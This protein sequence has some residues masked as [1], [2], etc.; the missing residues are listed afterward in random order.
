[1]DAF[2]ADYELSGFAR[3]PL[4]IEGPRL[5]ALAAARRAVE[6]RFSDPKGQCF[7][8]KFNEGTDWTDAS[9]VLDVDMASLVGISVVFRVQLGD[10]A[11]NVVIR[12]HRHEGWTLVSGDLYLKPLMALES[13]SVGVR[14]LVAWLANAATEL[15]LVLLNV[16]D[17]DN[18]VPVQDAHVL[19]PALVSILA[20]DIATIPEVELSG[21]RVLLWHQTPEEMMQNSGVRTGRARELF[22]EVW[23]SH[24]L[25]SIVGSVAR[26]GT[27]A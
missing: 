26:G 17:G 18:V 8:A 25:G 12:I 15:D 13:P 3:Q 19:Q 27:G 23:N 24:R 7:L 4:D 2:L 6:V 22:M 16:A 20:P 10:V 11:T 1:M 21:A 14:E 5:L 9:K